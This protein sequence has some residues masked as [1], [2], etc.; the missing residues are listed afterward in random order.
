MKI[1]CAVVEGEPGG[2]ADVAAGDRRLPDPLVGQEG[3]QVL[4]GAPAGTPGPSAQPA[5]PRRCCPAARGRSKHVVMTD[6]MRAP[7]TPAGLTI[8]SYRPVRPR[9]RAAACG[10]SSSSTG[11]S[12]TGTPR[13]GGRD[14]GAGFEEYLTRLDLSGGSGSPTRAGGG[15]RRV[16]RAHP[17]GPPRRRAGPDRGRRR[18]APRPGHRPGARRERSPMV[19]RRGLAPATV[20]PSARDRVR[21]CTPCTR[22]ASTGSPLS[23]WPWTCRTPAGRPRR[24]SGCTTCSSGPDPRPR[25]AAPPVEKP[26]RTGRCGSARAAGTAC[27]P[28]A[29]VVH[30]V[31]AT[32]WPAQQADDHDIHR[33][34]KARRA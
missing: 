28:R 12:S 2:G 14:P 16:R 21:R 10:R 25:R 17:R 15:R 5:Y 6:T 32:G 34:G 24:R 4:P 19:R 27:G 13:L 30:R 3:R 33:Q 11:A 31:S 29:R 8:R 22:P 7:T 23:N 20:S 9:R 1:E 18:P 26:H